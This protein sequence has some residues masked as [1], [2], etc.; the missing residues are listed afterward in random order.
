MKRHTYNVEMNWVGNDG[1]GT[2]DYRSYRRDHE[3][4]AGGKPAIPGSSDPAFRG[5]P[6][7]YSPEELLVSSLSSCHMLWY[8]HLCAVNGVVVQDYRDSAVG[9]MDENP[10]GSGQFT[11]VLLRPKILLSP[12]SDRAKAASLHHE[13]HR[14]CFLARSVN[15]PVE[16][17]PEFS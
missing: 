6:A 15:F 4:H 8:L 1:R 7:R 16:C 12:Q 2:E 10:D 5:D 11:R 17:A 13:A 14:F 9:E 3:T